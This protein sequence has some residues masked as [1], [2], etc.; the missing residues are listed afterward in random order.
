MK[1]LL[2]HLHDHD[3]AALETALNTMSNFV[4][5]CG[6]ESCL[7]VLLVNGEAVTFFA[8]GSAWQR[9]IAAVMAQP[10]VVVKLCRHALN[11]Y[12]IPES[13]LIAGCTVVPFGIIA[14]VE[15]EQSGFAYV[16]A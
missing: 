6:D 8:A 13:G 11:R 15:L 2:M 14:L 5:A 4:K 10:G 12:Q 7:A 3:P 1:K 9:E 16:K